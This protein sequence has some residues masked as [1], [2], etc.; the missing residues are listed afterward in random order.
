MNPEP[1][2]RLRQGRRDLEGITGVK[3]LEDF[4]WY[5]GVRTWA[6]RVRL[7][8]EGPQSQYVPRETDWYI[9]AVDDY[10]WGKLKFC[11]AKRDSIT[12]TFHHQEY[13]RPYPDDRPWTTGDVCLNT[14]VNILGRHGTEDEP[15]NAG[16]RR[17]R[18]RWHAHRALEWLRLAASGE[19]VKEGEPFEVPHFPGAVLADTTVVFAEDAASFEVWNA[20]T[21]TYGFINLVPLAAKPSIHA[22]TGFYTLPGQLVLEQRW[23][24]GTVLETPPARGVWLRISA[25]LANEPWQAPATW[26][27]L[28][29]A[30]RAGRVDLDRILMRLFRSIR[31][32]Q[33]HIL[34]VGFPMPERIGGKHVRMH[35]QPIRLPVLAEGGV[36][37]KG[38]RPGKES[39]PYYLDR[40]NALAGTAELEWLNSENWSQTQLVSRGVLSD[41][42]VN[43]HVLLLGGGAIGSVV[44]E[45]LI[46]AGLRRLTIVDD[47]LMQAGNLCRHTLTL[48][49]VKTAKAESL[50]LRL[51]GINP[52]AEVDF[53][54]DE[55]PPRGE[56]AEA[57]TRCDVV[58]DCT[59]DD[60]VI[61]H[62][63]QFPWSGQKR[64]V[65]ISL[66]HAA[67]RLFCFFADAPAFP[68]EQFRRALSP[69]LQK[70]R[71][72]VGDAE[73]PREGVGC[74]HPVFPARSDD[75]WMM[76]S[77]AVKHL[78]E[79]LKSSTPA[80][81]LTIYEQQF[82]GFAFA[83]VARVQS[84]A[85]NG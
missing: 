34:L 81:G 17:G 56:S 55:F 22:V 19:L 11:P 12:A 31:D 62:L 52:H 65:S 18:M 20:A 58:I 2:A 63:G 15:F 68:E 6:I 10:P 74:W 75:V 43:S 67:R 78:E 29:R 25:P 21:M 41:Y 38:F 51:R 30:C 70:D 71:E 8:R 5:D 66:G 14:T 49:D 23:A 3:L 77:I 84:E 13:N 48:P 24:P 64:F 69:W 79:M 61:H 4:V 44:A 60:A 35:W 42:L 39:A 33:Q 72:E 47:E 54:T 73:L 7:T 45:L 50:A 59:A 16:G 46:R 53:V 40:S 76:A 80:N 27:E 32:G 9:L 26:S 57:L 28:C 36:I 37:R 82:N 85:A 83:G 1:S